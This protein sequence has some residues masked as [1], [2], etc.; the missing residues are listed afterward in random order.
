[1]EVE[2]H[3]SGE[4]ERFEGKEIAQRQHECCKKAIGQAVRFGLVRVT[5]E[6]S[7]RR[8]VEKK[9]EIIKR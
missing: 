8:Q 7:P 2:K 9:R 3:C 4:E 1:L 5:A 6:E